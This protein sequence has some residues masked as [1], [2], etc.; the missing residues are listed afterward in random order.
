MPDTQNSI[1]HY[2][3]EHY[4]RRRRSEASQNLRRVRSNLRG[5]RIAEGDRVLDIGCGLG[6]TGL[7][8]AE[9][10]ATPVGIDISFEACRAAFE[11]GGYLATSQ[12]NAELLPLVDLS[13][14]AAVFMGTLEHFISPENALRE[15]IR[16]LKPG[17]QLCFVVPNSNF[18]LFRLLGG[19]GQ[20]H[21]VPR[22]REGWHELFEGA[23]LSIE[24][25]Y[26]DIGPGV[27]E[28]N[29]PLRGLMRRL[30]LSFSNLMPL[31][32]AYQFVF[33][34]HIPA[35]RLEH[36]SSGIPVNQED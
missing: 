29:R 4:E 20:P 36:A 13:S 7:Y 33:V 31:R 32:C 15:A 1:R 8:L 30:V 5:L 2:Y 26:R 17:A 18:L 12:A 23:G 10:G 9:Q 22:T 6:T 28:G 11:S 34:C 25:V 14:D 19:T 16:V 3:E 24:M 35:K 21:E 27:F